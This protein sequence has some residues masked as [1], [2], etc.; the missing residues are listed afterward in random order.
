MLPGFAIDNGPYGSLRD[1][2]LSSPT[3]LIESSGRCVGRKY[4]ANN[5]VSEFGQSLFGAF[6]RASLSVTISI[7]GRSSV[8]SQIGQGDI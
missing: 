2:Q 7:V 8:P 3:A 1:V 5:V 6:C 4:L